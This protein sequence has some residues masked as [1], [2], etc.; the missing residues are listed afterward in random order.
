MPNS[1]PQQVDLDYLSNTLEAMEDEVKAAAARLEKV[2]FIDMQSYL[3]EGDTFVTSY[4]VPMLFTIF[5]NFVNSA[6][7]LYRDHLQYE[8]I[9][10]TLHFP[11]FAPEIRTTCLFSSI[12]QLEGG[13][14]ADLDKRMKF[15]DQL[16]TFFGRSL[17]PSNIVVKMAGNI[18]LHVLNDCLRQLSL[19]LIDNKD[20][21]YFGENETARLE[22]LLSE[23]KSRRNKI[24]HSI[25][26]DGF[27]ITKQD[28]TRFR[29]GVA[30]VCSKIHDLML[31][32]AQNRTYLSSAP[33]AAPQPKF[34]AQ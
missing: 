12:S 23:L 18:D 21:F 8:V 30:Y 22:S 1:N 28:F 24:S 16:A 29:A 5:E 6:L 27:V 3:P 17:S 31:K 10:Q 32:A 13:I 20:K 26:V 9:A 7:K 2:I 11:A 25:P 19:P 4:S 14:P 15:A 34:P 33:L